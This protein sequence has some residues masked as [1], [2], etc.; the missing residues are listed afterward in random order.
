MKQNLNGVLDHGAL[1]NINFR[2]GSLEAQL[3][4]EDEDTIKSPA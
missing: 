2:F 3:Y 4:P 1:R